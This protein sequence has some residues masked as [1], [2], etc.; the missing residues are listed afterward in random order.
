MKSK[1]KTS[2]ILI[3]KFSAIES[4]AHLKMIQGGDTV[5]CATTNRLIHIIDGNGGISNW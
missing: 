2:V 3:N 5:A 4:Q 1:K